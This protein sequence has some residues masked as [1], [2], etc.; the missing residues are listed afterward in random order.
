MAKEKKGAIVA[1]D[2]KEARAKALEVALG[3]I[4]KDF[5][6]G[7]VMK[8]GKKAEGMVVE[9][10][11]TG[12]LSVDAALGVGGFPKGRIVEIYGPESSGK[13]TLALHAVASCQNAGGTAAF[14]DAEHALDPVYAKK[15][16]VD[17]DEL[18]VSQPDNGEQ[19]LDICEA[20]VRSGAIDIV[21]VDSVAALVPRAEIEG[22]M[23]DS[24]VGLQARLMSQ[25]LRKITGV[26][27]NTKCIVI[28]I[29]QL[30]EK[31]GVMYGNPET[32]TGGKALKF[33]ASIRIDIR[34]SEAIKEGK[35]VVGNKTKIK[36]V[37]N[38][39][40]PPFRSTTVEVL[41][42]EGISRLGEVLDYS[43]DKD[44]IKKSGSF[45]S[46]NGERIGQGR[47]NVKAWLK[48]NPEVVK[49]LEDKIREELLKDPTALA[50]EPIET[51]DDE[52]DDDAKEF[53]LDKESS[54]EPSSEQNNESFDEFVNG[55]DREA[56]S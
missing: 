38:K 3:K 49:D 30:R 39:V 17:I 6:K 26:V 47:D 7:S 56:V 37:K 21:V 41:Y 46:Y 33:Y 24:H 23:G 20:L 5:G 34:K 12:I 50:E 42:G 44:L 54:S 2:G 22:D 1:I 45:Y 53:E 13:T 4:E 14:I 43:V 9:V 55:V 52:D 51:S 35:E 8:L 19:A 27:S 11:P 18:Y 28:F 15:L 16:G 29:N 10:L 40:A 31:V 48:A 25:A 32:T 36:I